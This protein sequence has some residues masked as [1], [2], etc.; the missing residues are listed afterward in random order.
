MRGDVAAVEGEEEEEEGEQTG[1]QSGEGEIQWAR[2]KG[3][4]HGSEFGPNKLHA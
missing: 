3:R 2:G 4:T 1:N